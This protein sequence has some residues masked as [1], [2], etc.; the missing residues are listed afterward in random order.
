MRKF[1]S[2]ILA[3]MLILSMATVAFAA[4]FIDTANS[5]YETA[6]DTMSDMDV[7]EGYAY[8][9]FCPDYSLTRAEAA[10][11]MV[12]A[13][14]GEEVVKDVID[15]D[16]VSSKDWFYEYVNTAV[17]YGLVRGM[18]DKKFAPNDEVTVDQMMTMV[19]NALGYNAAK[20]SGTWPENVQTIGSSLHLYYNFPVTTVGS[21]F[22][23][24]G[25]ACQ[26]IYNAL[27]CY[28]VEYVRG[29]FVET[30]YTLREKMGFAEDEVIEI[31]VVGPTD[32][33]FKPAVNEGEIW[34]QIRFVKTYTYGDNHEYTGF[35][36]IFYD[37]DTVY[38]TAGTAI[39]NDTETVQLYDALTGNIS[40][41]DG[42][43]IWLEM[44]YPGSDVYRIVKVVHS[45]DH[46]PVVG[47]ENG[48]GPVVFPV[49]P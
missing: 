20:L 24:R 23:S 2:C 26:M 1:I 28:C 29:R 10:T 32:D 35:E 49:V 11:I 42:D 37:N 46:V 38:K 21:A 13:L 47:P 17:H 39:I 7:V 44:T 8:G 31:P 33:Y 15:F 4:E 5:K 41:A 43:E 14:Y 27:D 36:I 19:L 3:I 40:L 12:R 18:G 30:N 16:D 45:A 22:V 9:Y 25:Q 34:G 48:G 6:I